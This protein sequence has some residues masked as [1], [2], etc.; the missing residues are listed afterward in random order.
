MGNV[1]VKVARVAYMVAFALSSAFVA[2][3]ALLPGVRRALLDAYHSWEYMGYAVALA[4]AAV[5]LAGAFLIASRDSRAW[6]KRSVKASTS[7]GEIN[8]SMQAIESIAVTA[9][10]RVQGVKESRA[11]LRRGDDGIEVT[12]RAIAYADHNI[13]NLCK[14]MQGKV[15]DMIEGN[16]GVRVTGVR[17]IVDNVSAQA[18]PRVE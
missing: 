13:P 1:F 12:A 15:K 11:Y 6:R 2:L 14:E 9:S 5:A 17:V 16:A 7:I 3:A 8:I 18:K 10:R 4:G